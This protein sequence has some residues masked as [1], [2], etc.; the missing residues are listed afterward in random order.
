M[1]DARPKCELTWLKGRL[2]VRLPVRIGIRIRARLSEHTISRNTNSRT[3]YILNGTHFFFGKHSFCRPIPRNVILFLPCLA[4]S[5]PNRMWI[6]EVNRRAIRM[7]NR[8]VCIFLS[9]RE[10]YTHSICSKSY[11]DSYG[12][13][14]TCKP[15]LKKRRQRY[16]ST[17]KVSLFSKCNLFMVLLTMQIIYDAIQY[18]CQVSFLAN[19]A[20]R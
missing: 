1:L 4:L 14:Y 16:R 11:A 12:K 13:S 20:Q 9:Y 18:P 15:D 19:W 5:A 10:L 8:F 6:R 17:N 7:Q 2:H 3:F